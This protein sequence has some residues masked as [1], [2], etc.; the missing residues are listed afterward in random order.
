VFRRALKGT[1]LGDGDRVLVALSGGGD[2]AGL[3]ALLRSALPRP[4]LTLGAVHVHHNL[5]GAEADRDAS[6]AKALAECTGVEFRLVRL[7][8]RPPRGTSLEA[9]A[10]EARYEALERLRKAGHWDW[11]VTAHTLDDQAETLLLRIAR[12]TGLDGLAGILPRR[13]PLVRP[14]L[15][16]T[17]AQLEEAAR[18]CGLPWVEDSSNADRRFLRSR[19]RHDLLPALESALPGFTLHLAALARHAQLAAGA[20]AVPAVAVR[21]SGTVYLPLGALDALSAGDGREVVRQGLRDLRGDLSR[22]TERHV[23]A[24][25]GLRDAPVGAVVAL[26]GPWEGVRERG[27]VRLR[28]AAK[29]GER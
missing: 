7:R 25:W 14:A 28:R 11:I 5:R 3:L 10:R 24:L 17:S 19:V 29:G 22:I 8:S 1:P 20:R 18:L 6:L 9:W 12:G 21:D 16:M 2:S 26:P 27:G 23:A 15:E 13:G 4:A